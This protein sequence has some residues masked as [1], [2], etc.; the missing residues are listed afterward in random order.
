MPGTLLWNEFRD[1]SFRRILRLE[2]LLKGCATAK[3]HTRVSL[4]LHMIGNSETK[5]LFFFQS[6]LLPIY[7]YIL[8][9]TSLELQHACLDLTHATNRA[10]TPKH[11]LSMGANIWAYIS[12]M[13]IISYYAVLILFLFR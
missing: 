4:W 6:I 9:Q 3:E 7:R 13:L 11:S 8:K 12:T 2:W 5:N 10:W 1:F